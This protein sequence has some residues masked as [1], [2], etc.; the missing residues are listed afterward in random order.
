MTVG[1]QT[2]GIS[3]SFTK[4]MAMEAFVKAGAVEGGI[5]AD[6]GGG[7]GELSCMLATKFQHV[8]LLDYDPPAI[9]TLAGNIK[10]V[11]VDLNEAW[12]MEDNSV[13]FAFST[14]VI[15]H[16]HNPRHFLKEMVRITRPGG[17]VFLSTP[18]NHSLA[19]KLI[20]ILRGQHRY[21]QD[22]SYPAHIT[23]LLQIDLSR[24][25]N[26]L[27]LEFVS[28]FWSGED[29]IPW[30]NWKIPMRVPA[31]SVSIGVLYRLPS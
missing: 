2:Q 16:V 1:I 31:F 22:A 17:H 11:Q 9:G 3:P 28:W 21:F 18:N 30:L 6:V 25:G 20:F 19:S 15:E 8:F 13:D 26:E 27:G 14:E 29:S 4:R 12:P 10:G 7:V 24:M 5:A 23:P